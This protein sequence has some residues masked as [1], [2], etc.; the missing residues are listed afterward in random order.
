MDKTAIP[1]VYPH[2]VDRL[3][4][5]AEKDQVAVFEIVLAHIFTGPELLLRGPRYVHPAQ[6]VDGAHKTAAIHPLD[7]IVPPPLVGDADETLSGPGCN[8]PHVA[9]A[10]RFRSRY[11]S[12]PNFRLLCS[13]QI[14]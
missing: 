7:H 14:G 10:L 12:G 8:G 11:V 9:A 6:V 1:H 5:T 2:M 3:L 13:G 4:R